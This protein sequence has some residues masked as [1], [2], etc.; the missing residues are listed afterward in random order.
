MSRAKV[1]V[2]S[3]GTEISKNA[4]QQSKTKIRAALFFVGFDLSL[5]VAISDLSST[6]VIL[7]DKRK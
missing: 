3:T 6:S 7:P 1:T 4:R 5:Q 2:H